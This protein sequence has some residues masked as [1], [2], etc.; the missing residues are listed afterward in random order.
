MIGFR[1]RVGSEEESLDSDQDSDSERDQRATFAA[2]TRGEKVSGRGDLAASLA[3]A[4]EAEAT[5]GEG[6]KVESSRAIS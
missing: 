5:P 6:H 2:S 1:I 3:M 4:W